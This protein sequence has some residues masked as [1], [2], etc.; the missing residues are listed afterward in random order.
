MAG[1][2]VGVMA[3]VAARSNRVTLTLV[4]E[5]AGNNAANLFLL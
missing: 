2:G 3:V 1:V 4:V 5:L